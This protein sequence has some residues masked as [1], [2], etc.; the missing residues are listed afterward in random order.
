MAGDDN[1]YLKMMKTARE[2]KA[3]SATSETTPA[4]PVTNPK[5]RFGRPPGK[6]S[7]PEFRPITLILREAT[8]ETARRN[9][10][11]RRAGMDLSELV[12]TLLTG[13]NTQA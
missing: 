10:K 5:G 2:L 3:E 13:W 8:T 9:L 11:D 7:N 12:E 6:R 1:K 4:A